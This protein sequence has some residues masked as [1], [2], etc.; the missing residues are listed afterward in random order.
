M[1][2]AGSRRTSLLPLCPRAAS[3]ATSCSFLA[4]A[5]R[6]ATSSSASAQSLGPTRRPA[7]RADAFDRNRGSGR[8]WWPCGNAASPAHRQRLTRTPGLAQRGRRLV[9]VSVKRD[10]GRRPTSP[11]GWCRLRRL[12]GPAA[13][14]PGHLIALDLAASLPHLRYRPPGDQVASIAG[15]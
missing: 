2:V 9:G 13:N 12:P 1:A 10:R 5:S 6:S 14:E 11:A 3:C 8:T 15:G 4:V 7:K